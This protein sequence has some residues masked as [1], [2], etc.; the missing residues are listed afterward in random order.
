MELSDT[1]EL[2]ISNDWKERFKAEFW[3]TKIRY[4]RLCDHINSYY[5]KKPTSYEEEI[6]LLLLTTQC[7]IMC[8]YITALRN[9]SYL[10]GISDYIEN[11]SDITKWQTVY[12]N[13]EESENDD[14]DSK[15]I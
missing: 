9:R 3:Q 1:V 14:R 13:K 4:D 10:L 7:E 8:S 12:P 2:M 5:D 6:E 15:K 11:I